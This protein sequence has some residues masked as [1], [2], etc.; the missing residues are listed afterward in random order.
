M[1]KN[2]AIPAAEAL[3]DA[4]SEFHQLGDEHLRGVGYVYDEKLLD[5]VILTFDQSRLVIWGEPDDDSIEFRVEPKNQDASVSAVDASHFDHWKR[6]IGKH[7]G[8]GWI[9]MNQQGYCD[10]ILISFEDIDP[11]ILFVVAASSLSVS[12]I[13]RV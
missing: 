3:S 11:Q 10:G 13:G 7:F 6:L 4:L 1:K 12:T 5:Q 9:I 2:A 8:W